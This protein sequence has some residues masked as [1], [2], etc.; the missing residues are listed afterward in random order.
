MLFFNTNL[1][2]ESRIKSMLNRLIMQE[3]KPGFSLFISILTKELPKHS[4]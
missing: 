1:N 2:P 4:P 3:K